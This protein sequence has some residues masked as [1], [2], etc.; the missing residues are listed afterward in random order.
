MASVFKIF[1]ESKNIDDYTLTLAGSLGAIFNGAS[2]IFWATLQD[3]I[4]FKKVYFIVCLIQALVSSTIF[5]IADANKYLYVVWVCLSY[6]CLGAQFSIFPTAC[7]YI[8]GMK[9][10]GQI[11][12]FMFTAFGL[13]SLSG[14][15][16]A[17]FAL[18]S[19]GYET[20]FFLAAFL[21]LCSLVLLYFFNDQPILTE[22]NDFIEDMQEEEPKVHLVNTQEQSDDNLRF[23]A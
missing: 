17:K 11:Y 4:G 16:V 23:N 15:F 19:I 7:A 20:F 5:F 14:F 13:S 21:T 12:S 9:S 6:L 8:F 18:K 10:G 1:G 2:R 3:K 22:K